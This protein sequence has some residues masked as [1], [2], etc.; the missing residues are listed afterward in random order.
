M[1]FA[2]MLLF[3]GGYFMVD[4]LLGKKVIGIKQCKKTIKSGDG[5]ILYIAKDADERLVNPL[6]E[7]AREHDVEVKYVNTMKELGRMCGI[8][9]G[10]AATLMI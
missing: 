6:V 4:R 8:E 2:S 10:S 9:V 1:F 5:I 7:L 3:I